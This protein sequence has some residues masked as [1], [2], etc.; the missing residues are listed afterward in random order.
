MS[1]ML[2]KPAK[3]L[4]F[5]VHESLCHSLIWHVLGES[6]AKDGFIWP[7]CVAGAAAVNLYL[8]NQL[9]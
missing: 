8:A 9:Y 1:L 4:G 6:D 5:F 3:L 2:G 7:C